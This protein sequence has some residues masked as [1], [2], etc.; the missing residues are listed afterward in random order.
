MTKMSNNQTFDKFKF[1]KNVKNVQKSEKCKEV[2]K[3][4][5]L[6]EKKRKIKS[7]KILV[8]LQKNQNFDIKKLRN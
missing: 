4:S 3:M 7:S 1:L 2:T 5:Y 8:K 6:F